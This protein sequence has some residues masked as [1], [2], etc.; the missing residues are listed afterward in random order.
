MAGKATIKRQIDKSGPIIKIVQNSAKLGERCGKARGHKAERS[1]AMP[2]RARRRTS[3]P[4]RS[5][6]PTRWPP[7][8]LTAS[9]RLRQKNRNKTQ[10]RHLGHKTAS[11]ENPGSLDFADTPDTIRTCDLRFRKPTLYPAELRG[12]I[13]TAR[14]CCGRH[15]ARRRPRLEARGAARRIGTSLA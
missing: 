14:R 3:T 5:R 12:H 10:I 1:G 9:S 8:R 2:R 6:P 15:M 7:R 11:G 4:T 13:A